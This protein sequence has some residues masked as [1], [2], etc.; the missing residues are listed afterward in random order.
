M[1]DGVSRELFQ[2][3]EKLLPG[4]VNS[5]VRAFRAVGGNPVFVERAKGSKLYGADG[6]EYVDYVGSW[7]PAILGHAHPEVIAAVQAVAAKGLS[8]GAPTELEVRFAAAIAE[9][10]PSIEML[11]CV[12]SGTEATMSALRAARGFTGRDVIVKFDGAYH[13]HADALLVKAGSGLATFGAPD[14]AGV[15]AATVQGTVTAPYN[16]ADALRD[17]F[18]REGSRIAAVIVEPVAGNMGCVPPEPGFLQAIVSLCEQYGAV[19]IFDEV[20]T[21]SRLSRGGAQQRYG[22]K[23]AMTCLGKV[24][25]GGM[26]LA[27]YGGRADIMKTIAPLGPVYQAGTLSGNPL[28]VTAG[29]KT[30]ELLTPASYDALE[31]TSARLEQGLAQALAATNVRG[32]VQRVGSMLTL[33]FSEAPVRSWTDAARCDTARFGVFHRGLTE[34]GVYWPPS[35]FEAAFVSIA[36]TDADVD[37]TVRAATEALAE[38]R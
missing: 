26:P 4:G 9:L 16:D 24:V 25:G 38:A 33:F 1:S 8:F 7:G 23:P 5:P 30:L 37:L 31:R 10:Y 29:L 34:R 2:R 36:H 11:R 32:V 35:Q 28:A 21:G 27:V 14:S 20:M 22:L 19:S 15:P 3:A 6:K 18:A 17:L 12:S 13:G